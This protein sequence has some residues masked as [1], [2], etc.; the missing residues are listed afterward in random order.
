MI[1]HPRQISH[2]D[3]LVINNKELIKNVNRL[4]VKVACSLHD[5]WTTTDDNEIYTKANTIGQMV[6]THC[7]Q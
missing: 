4:E 5:D 1:S 2:A 6:F 3:C 7:N